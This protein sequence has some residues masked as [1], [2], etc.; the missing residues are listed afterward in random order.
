MKVLVVAWG[1][2]ETVWVPLR[3]VLGRLET[4]L[5]SSWSRLEVLSGGL[6]ASCGNLGVSWGGLGSVLG[7][8][9][10]VLGRLGATWGH[11]AF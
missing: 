8:L 11:L 3:K 2:R 6:G 7:R 9:G 5:G 4:I 10:V 1:G